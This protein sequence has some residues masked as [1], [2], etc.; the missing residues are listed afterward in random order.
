MELEKNDIP[1]EELDEGDREVA[2][3]FEQIVLLTAQTHNSL[4]YQRRMN[5]L[6]TLIPNST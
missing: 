3:L 4:T 1:E 5:V 2:N 6:S